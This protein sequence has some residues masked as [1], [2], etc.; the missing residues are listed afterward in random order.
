M[1]IINIFGAGLL[2]FSG[3]FIMSNNIFATETTQT[4]IVEPAKPTQAELRSAI[5]SIE[6]L[7]NYHEYSLLSSDEL[8]ATTEFFREY[9]YLFKIVNFAKNLDADYENASAQDLTDAI[10][11]AGHAVIA[12]NLIF[13]STHKNPTPPATSST[14]TSAPSTTS[15]SKPVITPAITTSNAQTSTPT[16]IIATTQTAPTEDQ[17]DTTPAVTS[18]PESSKQENNDDIA[19]PATGEVQKSNKPLFI[20]LGIVAL[21]CLL[22]GS[23]IILNRKKPYRPGRKF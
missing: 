3:S 18:A 2:A 11:A 13:N 6:E 5:T 14:P 22:V 12:C 19:V 4:N 15:S 23:M 9:A 7:E 17:P 10:E 8:A 16:N 20:T 21:A 1:K